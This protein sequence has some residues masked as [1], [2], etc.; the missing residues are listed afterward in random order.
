MSISNPQRDCSIETV[1]LSEMQA[2]VDQ[3]RA[4]FIT[5]GEVSAETRI[6]RIDLMISILVD[7]ADAIADALFDDFGGR[8][9]PQSLM[10][11]IFATIK[12]LKHNKKHLHKWM[13]IEKRSPGFPL[14]LLGASA[15]I[16]YQPKGVVGVLGT[17][18]FPV[19]TVIGPLA[20]IFAAGNRA[21][22][23]FSE[24]TPKTAAIM[25]QLIAE[26]Y[27]PTVLSCIS[28]GPE[29][30][31]AFSS[32]KLDHLIF[33]GSGGIAKHVMTNAAK[34]LTPVT[35]ELGGKSPVIIAKDA[36]IEKAANRIS[37]G[38]LL[39]GGQVCISPD[40]IFV[41][42]DKIDALVEQIQVTISKAFPSMIDNDDYTSII[43]ARHQQRLMDYIQDAKTK[44]TQVIEINPAGEDFS[45]QAQS[46]KI[47]FTL[48]LNPSDDCKIMQNEIFGTAICIKT[49]QDLNQ[50][51]DYINQHDHPLALYLFTDDEETKQQVISRT[52]SGGVCI[53]DVMMHVTSDDLPFGG[54]GGSGMG[55]YHGFDGFKTFSHAKPVFKQSKLDLQKMAGM[56]PPY[57]KRTHKTLNNMIKK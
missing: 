47:P 11:D 27:D 36:D 39:N 37:Y 24:V 23:K 26:H 9:K 19:H 5:E 52:I 28:G 31:A 32:L 8:P 40:Y 55:N 53:N 33:T 22:V 30:G 56:L 54:I 44:G 43:N 35:L 38:K 10:S 13:K 18:N 42:E 50:C 7:N 12:Q 57:T 45:T 41:P 4:S 20:D 1:N 3:Q 34:N 51:I 21:I 2:K 29:V 46:H 49:Y 6:A 17:W 15:A 16:H 25:E 14:N 48:V